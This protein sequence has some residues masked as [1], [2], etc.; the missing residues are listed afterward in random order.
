MTVGRVTLRVDVANLASALQGRADADRLVVPGKLAP[1][2]SVA[3]TPGSGTIDLVLTEQPRTA[4]A[5]YEIRVENITRIDVP[6]S[7]GADVERWADLFGIIITPQ[8]A[9]V[10]SSLLA[11]MG[12]FNPTR[13]RFIGEGELPGGQ[14]AIGIRTYDF[15]DDAGRKLSLHHSVEGIFASFDPEGKSPIGVDLNDCVA[16]GPS[17]DGTGTKLGQDFRLLEVLAS[18]VRSALSRTDGEQVDGAKAMLEDLE[19]VRHSS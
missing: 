17:A 1:A 6:Q 16:W 3:T 15:V 11:L 7:P 10:P 12:G 18:G 8:S 4:R 14:L 2:S 19:A 5:G 9:E 13:M